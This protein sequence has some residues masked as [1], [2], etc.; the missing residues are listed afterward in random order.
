MSSPSE[1][2][3]TAAKAPVEVYADNAELANWTPSEAPPP[4]TG[5]N[6][7]RYV[8]ALNRFKWLIIVLTAIGGATGYVATRFIEPEY[9]VESNITLDM[10]TAGG[11]EGGPI[12][13]G[14]SLDKTSWVDLLKSY[15]V[16]D[17][18][19]MKQQLY[20]SHKDAADSV[21]FRDFSINPAQLV[22][23]D[24]VLKVDG[25]GWSLAPSAGDYPVDSG[26]VGDSIG[27]NRGFLWQPSAQVL[28]GHT[29]VAFTVQTPREASRAVLKNLVTGL[30]TGKAP[31][32]RLTYTGRNAQKLASTLNALADQ[33]TAEA[34]AM[35][36][37]RV[38]YMATL[39]EGQR[40][41]AEQEMQ[42]AESQLETFRVRTVTEP[43]ERQTAVAGGLAMTTPAVMN[44][45]FSMQVAVQNLQRDRANLEGLL[46]ASKA[47]RTGL[48]PE[49]ILSIPSINT[50]PAA[51]MVLQRLGEQNARETELAKIRETRM[52]EDKEVKLAIARLDTV[53]S[54]QAPRELEAYIAQIKIKEAALEKQIAVSGAAL[55]DIP[56]RTIQEGQLVRAAREAEMLFSS[57]DMET[58][59]A[60]LA[61][62]ATIPD[63]QVKDSAVPPLRPTKNTAPML[64]AGAVVA[65]LLLGI[66]LAVLLDQTDKRFR[67]PEQATNDLGLYILGVVPVIGGKG[68]RGAEQA[69]QVVETFRSIRMNVRY[70]TEPGR[71][72]TLTVTSPGPNDGKSLISS[73]L[74]L[75]FAEA[76]ARTLLIDGDIRRG[77][78]SKTFGT[79]SKP[80]LVEYL[81]G[82]ALMDEVLQPTASHPNLTIIPGGARRRRAPELLATPKLPQLI[83]QLAREYDVII[84]D[85]PP[86]GA[87]FDA[88]ALST[89]TAN[90]AVVLRAGITDRKLAKA[91]LATVD[92][93]PI[94]VI[95]TV[96]NSIKLSGAYQYY[97]YYQDYSAEDEETTPTPRI[98]GRSESVEISVPA[99]RT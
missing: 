2:Q 22:P 64:V 18:V 26:A 56:K 71:A 67:Y 33:F 39:L 49:A 3:V 23:G 11:G 73:N 72:L 98:A 95:G 21:V 78:L 84:V 44:E 62:A 83:A 7:Q 69:A 42:K 89:A 61:E 52:D 79:P 1:H 66:V 16:V 47:S 94:R 77:E 54:I 17:P 58:Q 68:R 76:G 91:K 48:A 97:S 92:Q 55:Q 86:L 20:L 87:G 13:D 80:G 70:A 8:S 96:L 25:R 43:N 60:R 19:V 6:I 12:T 28:A 14:A 53:K 40:Q 90:M 34:F 36:S 30:G 82:S 32:L 27:A 37:I 38:K 57:L 24:Y 31:F 50:D 85:S 93:L 45:Y 46:T 10:S 65:A 99:S 35:K 81:D 88:F 75:S 5:P 9:E 59:K 51:R 63:I 15:S 29:E 4:T 41:F 74:A